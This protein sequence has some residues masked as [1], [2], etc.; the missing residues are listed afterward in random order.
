M[1]PWCVGKGNNQFVTSIYYRGRFSSVGRV[2]YFR[3]GG[4]IP[5]EGP[6][7]SGLDD[8]GG[9]VSSWRRKKCPQLMTLKCNALVFQYQSIG[10]TE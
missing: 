1:G 9:T 10:M 7:L 2:F 5:V 8:H 3:A 6:I 4:P